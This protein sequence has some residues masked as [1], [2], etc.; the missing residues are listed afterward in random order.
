MHHLQGEAERVKPA[1][2]L[3]VIDEL[4]GDKLGLRQRH[5]AAARLVDHYDFNNTYQY[6]IAREDTHLAW[7]SAAI[8]DLGGTPGVLMPEPQVHAAGRGTA[9]LTALF[10]DDVSLAD[11][12]V[13]KW[14]TRIA[15]ITNAR[16]RKMCEIL[17]GETREHRRMFAQALEGREDVLGRRTG[18]QTTGGGVLATRWVE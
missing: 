6:I 12:F 5:A 17:L 16:H 4:Y 18:G 15:D 9:R 7:L 13:D 1:E 11:A 2:L 14:Q 10:R 3:S 8:A